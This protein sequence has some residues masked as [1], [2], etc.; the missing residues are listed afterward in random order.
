MVTLKLISTFISNNGRCIL[1]AS[2]PPKPMRPSLNQWILFH[3]VSLLDD[4][5]TKQCLL[6]LLI[7]KQTSHTIY[8]VFDHATNENTSQH[9]KEESQ[10]ID[11]PKLTPKT[12]FFGVGGGGGGGML[13]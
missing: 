13:T 3:C 9:S 12:I 4:S 2:L 11:K 6:E 7:K 8:R 10:R 1:W 5:T